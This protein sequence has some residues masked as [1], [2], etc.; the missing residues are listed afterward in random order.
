MLFLTQPLWSVTEL[1]RYLRDLLESDELLQ[2]IWIQGEISNLARPASGHLY[3]TLK[4]PSSTVRCVMWRASATRLSFAPRD[5]MVVQ[6]HGSL[7]V[8]EAN[9]QYQLYATE[10]RPAGEGALYQEFLKLKAKLE[11]EGLFDP[12]RK[13]PLPPFPQ[14]LGIVTSPTGAAI[15]DILN[16]LRRRYPPLEVI[17]APTTVQG[18]D[19]PAGIISAIEA[20]NRFVSP[21]II[22]IARGGGSIE[23]LWGFNDESVARAIAASTAPVITGIGHETDYTIA[24]F[25]SD[26]RAPTPTAAAEIATP[27]KVE[28]ISQLSVTESRLNNLVYQKISDLTRELQ[29]TNAQLDLRSPQK[30]IQNYRQRLDESLRLADVA[31]MHRLEIHRSRLEN[32]EMRIFSLSPEAVLRRGYAIVRK[33]QGEYVVSA[34]N[35]SPDES[36]TVQMHDGE[37]PVTVNHPDQ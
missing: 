37:F 15:Q 20:L 21:D 29:R 19:A 28:L 4:D 33:K 36:L 34:Q 25:V 26:L 6:V 14:T 27:N 8:Y 5:G 18:I 30:M 3:F 9:G 2:D 17:I 32:L 12:S 35:V 1:N 31:A 23:D 13:R 22:L 16:T 10:I 7:G 24:D 11:E